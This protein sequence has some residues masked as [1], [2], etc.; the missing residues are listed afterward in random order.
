[1]HCPP[2]KAD[3]L[4]LLLVPQTPHL[5][6]LVQGLVDSGQLCEGARLMVTGH[7]LG[8]ALATLAAFDIK[9]A[10]AHFRMQLYTYGSPYPGNRAFSREF[11][12]LLPDT[13]HV[14]HGAACLRA[15]YQPVVS[16]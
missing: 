12:D 10:M 4:S 9:Q 7:S 13:W 1:M 3:Q 15:P 16:G 6:P 5:K 14:I 11:N 2:C 8:G